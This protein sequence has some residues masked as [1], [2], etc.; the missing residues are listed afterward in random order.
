MGYTATG[1]FIGLAGAFGLTR[2]MSAVLFGVSAADPLV[3]A[4]AA[5]ALS[6][7]AL[8]A[9]YVPARRASSVDPAIALRYEYGM[10]RLSFCE[11]NETLQRV[12]VERWSRSRVLCEGV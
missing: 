10:T 7:V 1:I 3:F 6:L 11:A 2:L 4:T 12:E 9:S 8:V 5:A